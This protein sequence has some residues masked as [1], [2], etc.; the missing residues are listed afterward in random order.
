METLP[1]QGIAPTSGIFT[2][3]EFCR[4]GEDLQLLNSSEVVVALR[5]GLPAHPL[6]AEGPAVLRV[7]NPSRE[8]HIRMTSS[9]LH[10]VGALTESLGEELA[11]RGR[12]EEREKAISAE[13]ENLLRELQ[14]RVKNS[15]AV[16]SSIASLEAGRAQETETKEAL[17]GLEARVVALASLY[18][19]L[20][21]TGSIEKIGL[22]DYLGRVV[23]FAAMSLGADA[24]GIAVVREIL[25][26]TLDVKRAIS[27]GLIVNELVTDSLK[28]AFPDGRRGRVKLCVSRDGPELVLVVAD[29]GVGLN[30][31]LSAAGKS[32]FGLTLVR[33]LASGLDASFAIHSERGV[34]FEL[35]MPL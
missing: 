31:G 21:F 11:E 5:E 3:G 10:F 1:F 20:Y 12:A 9:L 6:A 29:D 15:L 27:L 34:R 35:R 13:K 24:R 4:L 18:D 25:G 28:Y 30:P 17:E 23:D 7:A 14:H 16:I 19:I 22:A 2:S 32:G 33:S 26:I 8:R